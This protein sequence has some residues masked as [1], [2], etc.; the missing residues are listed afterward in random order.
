MA[1]VAL[2]DSYLQLDPAAWDALVGEGSPFLEHAYLA[3]LEA[4]GCAV[5]A[6]GWQP[7][8]VTISEGGRLIAAL[9][10][11]ITSHSRGEFVYDQGWADLAARHGIRYYPK[12][13]VG[14]PF[15]PVTGQRVL[16]A[17]G[18]DVARRT[19]ELFAAFEQ[20]QGQAH[21]LHVLFNRPDELG[22]LR[23]LGLFPRAQF[24]FH[25]E[26]AGYK[27]FEGFLAA[28][29][30]RKRKEI[31]RERRQVA[32]YRIVASERPSAT[33]IDQ[34]FDFYVHTCDQFA[35]WGARYLNRAFFQHLRER[36]GHR[37]LLFLAYED[38]RAVAGTFNVTKGDRL[39]GRY[40][41]AD[42]DRP[43]L[44]F[45]LCY[46]QTIEWCL[47]R[48]VTAFEPGHGGT[49]K[50]NR[51]FMPVL[52]WSAHRLVHRGLH[53]GLAKWSADEAHAV[54]AKADELAQLSPLRGL[55]VTGASGDRANKEA[56]EEP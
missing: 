45:E 42:G 34:M 23:A 14:V 20:L 40:W 5:P 44:H 32:Q 41:G 48:G 3:G 54:R 28:F 12:I 4:T 2:H 39:Y 31:R 37:I 35:M 7:C 21:G 11:W 13:V 29:P 24:Q 19:R 9:P 30:S 8:P 49:H 22:P 17:P 46:Y 15:T 16:I 55:V 52:T 50:Y 27:D 56:P 6:T 18:E 53:E 38:D 33:E 51:G 25:W 47:K 10:A 43:F 26:D 1:T 36:W